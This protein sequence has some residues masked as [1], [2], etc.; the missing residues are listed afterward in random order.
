MRPY[1]ARSVRQASHN[2]GCQTHDQGSTSTMTARPSIPV[3]AN[4]PTYPAMND[5]NGEITAL[6]HDGDLSELAQAAVAGAQAPHRENER[7]DGRSERDDPD[8]VNETAVDSYVEV[9][10][11]DDEYRYEECGQTGGT[12]SG[13]GHGCTSFRFDDTD[14]GNEAGRPETGDGLRFGV[15]A[16]VSDTTSRSAAS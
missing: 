4:T 11:D 14:P 13:G 7:G 3:A 12:G 5:R 6:T 16:A 9:L 15:G 2:Y 1:S 10:P 8:A